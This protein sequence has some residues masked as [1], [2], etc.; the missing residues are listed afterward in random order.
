MLKFDRFPETWVRQQFCDNKTFQV[1]FTKN[2]SFFAYTVEPHCR[3]VT[4]GKLEDA[5]FKSGPVDWLCQF[6]TN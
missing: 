3:A 1:C 4:L 5:P 2:Q 6:H